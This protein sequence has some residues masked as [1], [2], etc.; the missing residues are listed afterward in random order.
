MQVAVEDTDLLHTVNALLND[1]DC[2]ETKPGS[3][4]LEKSKI[5]TVLDDHEEMMKGTSETAA[6]LT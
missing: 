6:E 2:N 1:E 5:L 3:E 4:E